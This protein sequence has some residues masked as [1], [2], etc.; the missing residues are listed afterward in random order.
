MTFTITINKLKKLKKG[1]VLAYEQDDTY[2]DTL[3]GMTKDGYLVWKS[4]KYK[5]RFN[6]TDVI[7]FLGLKRIEEI[8]I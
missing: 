6:K 4:G 5:E 7:L 2:Y 3:L 1:I 8:K